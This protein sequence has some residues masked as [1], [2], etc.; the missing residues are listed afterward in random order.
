MSPVG[1]EPKISAG[2]TFLHN[3]YFFLCGKGKANILQLVSEIRLFCCWILTSARVQ[4]MQTK[5][6][7]IFH[8]SIFSYP[9]LYLILSYL[10]LSYLILSY[11]ILSYLPYCDFQVQAV[12]AYTFLHNLQRR[13]NRTLFLYSWQVA[14]C[15][16]IIQ[17]L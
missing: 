1:F 13:N 4:S 12:I 11:L 2:E 10:I 14:K 15:F 7:T 6:S 8:I 16:S 3:Y 5:R 9:T 17:F